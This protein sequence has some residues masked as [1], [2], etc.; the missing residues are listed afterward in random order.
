MS[1]K[2]IYQKN[3]SASILTDWRQRFSAHCRK[4]LISMVLA[5]F[6][7]HNWNSGLPV[8]VSALTVPAS[9]FEVPPHAAQVNDFDGDGITDFAVVRAESSQHL[10][11]Y[12]LQSSDQTPV[13][14]WFGLK[15]DKIVSSDYDG[16]RLTDAAVF[17]NGEWYVQKSS[18]GGLLWAQLGKGSDLPAEADYDGDGKT[19]FAVYQ[20]SRRIWTVIQSSDEQRVTYYFNCSECMEIDSRGYMPVPADYDNDGKADPAL[21][22]ND[23]SSN[24]RKLIIKNS[25]E[26]L[27]TSP[28]IWNLHLPSSMFVNPE[29]DGRDMDI[30]RDFN[31]DGHMDLAVIHES[32]RLLYW[33][34]FLGVGNQQEPS[35]SP[36]YVIQWGE[37]KDYPVAGDYVRN[38]FIDLAVWQEAT[39]N[40]NIRPTLN[41][42]MEGGL[43]TIYHWGM[44]GDIPTALG[45]R[46]SCP[47]P[48]DN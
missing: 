37:C 1:E 26:S 34:I 29:G 20:P 22:Q 4:I 38:G 10:I 11:W 9:S 45:G 12:I 30:P 40:F 36:N 41:S 24:P 39:G 35:L 6:F 46:V 27:V 32:G 7:L 19:D 3:R 42:N 33:M 17:R 2:K 47:P 31:K 43:R 48:I 14:K 18:D 8:K 44:S 16:D 21:M 28:G 13:Y 5:A 23:W 15:D 25:S